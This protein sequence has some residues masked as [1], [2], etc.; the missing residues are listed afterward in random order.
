MWYD[1]NISKLPALLLPGLV[2]RPL[3]YA[4]LHAILKPI[5]TIFEDWDTFRNANVYAMAHNGQVCYME[6]ALNDRFDPDLRRIYINPTGENHD[7][8]YIFTH[9]EQRPVFLGHIY[10]RTSQELGDTGVDFIV[11]VPASIAQISNFELRALVDFYRLASKRYL[12][13]EI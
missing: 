12:I 13:N 1:F 4:L 3:V 10:I 9:G 5:K 6:G 11:N 2:Q 7:P 8:T